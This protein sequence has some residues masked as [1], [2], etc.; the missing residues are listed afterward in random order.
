MKNKSFNRSSSSIKSKKDVPTQIKQTSKLIEQS[1]TIINDIL[2]DKAIPDSYKKNLITVP[3][4]MAEETKPKVVKVQA[5]PEVA[6]PLKLEDLFKSTLLKVEKLKDEIG[7]DNK[8]NKDS[9]LLKSEIIYLKTKLEFYKLKSDSYE[10]IYYSAK[11]LIDSGSNLENMRVKLNEYFSEGN[12]IY[13]DQISNIN[14]PDRVVSH[15][16]LHKLESELHSLLNTLNKELTSSKII[17]HSS[18]KDSVT[19]A[20]KKLIAL[21]YTNSESL[22]YEFKSRSKFILNNDKVIDTL[23]SKRRSSEL[24]DKFKA[25]LDSYKIS[26]G[27]KADIAEKVKEVINYY[28]SLNTV[29]KSENT[30]LKSNTSS[31]VNEVNGRYGRVEK[32]VDN[33]LVYTEGSICKLKELFELIGGRN[34]KNAEKVY[35]AFIKTEEKNFLD[36]IDKYDDLYKQFK[37]IR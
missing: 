19:I 7:L 13:Y 27:N 36:L 12:R 30:S 33:F 4:K 37:L 28:E 6:L 20:L 10:K 16:P 23:E 32:L 34:V 8:D 25:F 1:T 17:D 31:Y 5:S 26:S 18:L 15:D 9:I 21:Y 29:L 3:I 2:N 35:L 14:I 22:C 24:I 11:N